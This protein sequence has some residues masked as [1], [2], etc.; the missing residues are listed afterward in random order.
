MS[1]SDG[2]IL[3]CIQSQK[4][5]KDLGVDIVGESTKLGRGSSVKFSGTAEE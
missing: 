2:F 1:V 3:F 5:L 4:L